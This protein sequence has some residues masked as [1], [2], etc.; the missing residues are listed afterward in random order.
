M[1][2]VTPV[3][4]LCLSTITPSTFVFAQANLADLQFNVGTVI[5]VDANT[6]S[7]VNAGI[8]QPLKTL[9]AAVDKA[10]INSS[11]GLATRGSNKSGRIQRDAE[12]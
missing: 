9:Q 6:G 10:L 4:A 5:T 2:F 11:R 7:D 1:K 12:H 8:G 3:L